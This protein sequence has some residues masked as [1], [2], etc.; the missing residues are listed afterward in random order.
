[1]L[2][3]NIVFLEFYSADSENHTGKQQK[4]K[5]RQR[6]CESLSKAGV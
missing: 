2:V 3:V 1:M 4:Q 5:Y 6:T